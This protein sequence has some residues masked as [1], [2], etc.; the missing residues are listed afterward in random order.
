MMGRRK[1]SLAEDLM[2]ITAALPWWVGV[3]LA[4]IAYSILQH[5]AVLELPTNAVPGKMSH[6]VIEQMG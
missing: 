4:V 1:T 5:Y 6:V 2:D 3:I